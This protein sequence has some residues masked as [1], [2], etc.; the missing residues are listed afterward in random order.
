[1]RSFQPPQAVHMTA[2][3]LPPQTRA[4]GPVPAVAVSPG[5]DSVPFELQLESNDFPR[6]Q[7]ALTDPATNRVEWRSDPIAAPSTGL[8]PS[9]SV[10]VPARGLKPHHY[11]L[12]LMGLGASKSE[13]V[14]SYTFQVERR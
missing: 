1:S 12:A 14:G 6:Y 4:I 8:A 9:I 5:A 2:L 3:V 11:S 10:I 13:V 7:V